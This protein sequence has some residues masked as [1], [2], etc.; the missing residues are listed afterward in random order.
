MHGQED[1]PPSIPWPGRAG[2]LPHPPIHDP[3]PHRSREGRLTACKWPAPEATETG[4]NLPSKEGT[5]NASPSVQDAQT[6]RTRLLLDGGGLHYYDEYGGEVLL[7]GSSAE[8]FRLATGRHPLTHRRTILD[9]GGLRIEYTD[10][11]TGQVVATTDVG[12]GGDDRITLGA[13]GSLESVV[14][15]GASGSVGAKSGSFGALAVAGAT[16]AEHLDTRAKGVIKGGFNVR[17]DGTLPLRKSR[18]VLLRNWVTLE[19]NRQYRITTSGFKY[20]NQ[21]NPTT[22]DTFLVHRWND[23][24]TSRQMIAPTTASGSTWNTA[25]PAIFTFNTGPGSAYYT[26]TP[27][28]CAIEYAFQA[29]DLI[30][31]N[32]TPT[33]PVQLL[34]ED[35][36]P[37]TLEINNY[38]TWA[39]EAGGGTG[40][41]PGA[42]RT[43]VSRLWGSVD[44]AAYWASNGSLDSTYSPRVPIQGTWDGTSGNLRFGLWAFPNLTGELAGATINAID[45]E[46]TPTYWPWAPGVIRFALHGQSGIPGSMAIGALTDLGEVGGAYAGAPVRLSLPGS[47]FAGFLNGAYRGIAVYTGHTAGDRY[48]RLSRDATITINYTK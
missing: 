48:G 8:G 14:L 19:P 13:P 40:T 25:N 45:I 34:I 7:L 16:L 36:G 3:R 27:R 5:A 21:V 38:D 22:V 43:T 17:W 1:R 24:Q 2:P 39:S 42:G 9:N 11:E 18:A 33:D 26:A 15:D 32:A 12:N 28:L 37:W 29:S 35:I 44:A 41:T 47:R 10:P 31:I 20:S 46:V 6:T 4:R 30:Q 23:S